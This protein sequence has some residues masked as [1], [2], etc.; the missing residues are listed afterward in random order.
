MKDCEFHARCALSRSVSVCHQVRPPTLAMT[1]SSTM[2]SSAL[3]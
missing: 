3:T 1:R 2:P